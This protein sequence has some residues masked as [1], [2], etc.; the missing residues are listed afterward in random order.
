[1]SVEIKAQRVLLQSA[2]RTVTTASVQ[3]HDA[4]QQAV[5]V[6]LS[7][8]AASGTGGLKVFIRGYDKV[9]GNPCVL[10][11]GGAAAIVAIG[12]YCYELMPMA[13]TAVGGVLETVGR[14]LPSVWDIQ[15]TVGDASSYTYSVSCEVLPL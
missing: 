14:L 6:Y 4:V 7:I 15:T 5:R 1:M 12:T 11:G 2:A 13:S 10:N 3:Q 8:T 9:S